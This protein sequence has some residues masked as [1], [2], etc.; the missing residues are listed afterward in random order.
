[1]KIF[2]DKTNAKIKMLSINEWIFII[3]TDPFLFQSLFIFTWL[4]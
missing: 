3:P 4:F 1:M 2:T